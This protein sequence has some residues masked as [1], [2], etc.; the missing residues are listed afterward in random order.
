[1]RKLGLETA[2]RIAE[3]LPLKAW[4]PR[5]KTGLGPGARGGE[6]EGKSEDWRSVELGPGVDGICNC[7][8]TE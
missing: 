6:R 5:V 8:A 7:M 2:A 3:H 4:S 1:M